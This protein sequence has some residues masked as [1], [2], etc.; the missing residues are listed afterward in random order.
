MVA[1]EPALASLDELRHAH[2]RLRGEGEQVAAQAAE[3]DALAEDRFAD[4]G[5]HLVPRRAWW[6]VPPQVFARVTEADQLVSRVW[7]FDRRLRDLEGRGGWRQPLAAVERRRRDRAA[8]RLRA[9]L[10]AVGRCGAPTAAEVPDVGPILAEAAEL[11]A[12]GG[13]LRASLESLAPQLSELA[14]EIARREQAERLMGFDALHLAAWFTRHGMPEMES[15]YELEAGESA[16]L[17]MDAVLARPSPGAPYRSPGAG[18]VPPAAWTGI[19]FWMG[20]FR[21]GSAPVDP[22]SAEPGTLLL[23]SQRLAFAGAGGSVAIWLESAVDMDVYQD[24]IAVMH[25]DAAR[26]MIL[27]VRSPREVAFFINWALRSSRGT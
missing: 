10:A 16:Y 11:A 13:R 12:E 8:S 6:H 20:A 2:G 21:Q 25:M 27:R 17:E 4:A 19:Q 24:A 26:P 7:A 15:A 3:L 5:A 1:D 9:A 23:T 22:A 18:T 14:E